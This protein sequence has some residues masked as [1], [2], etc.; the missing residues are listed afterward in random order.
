MKLKQLLIAHRY[1]GFLD[2][3]VN[4]AGATGVLQQDAA[5]SALIVLK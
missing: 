2:G 1:L 3:E 4:P 5:S